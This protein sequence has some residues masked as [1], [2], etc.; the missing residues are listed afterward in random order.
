VFVRDLIINVRFSFRGIFND[1][2]ILSERF[3]VARGAYTF[4]NRI[5]IHLSKIFEGKSIP[6]FFMD[7]PFTADGLDI[8]FVR[9]GGM[10]IGIRAFRKAESTFFTYTHVIFA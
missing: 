6:G 4:L 5:Y 7:H 10:S 3:L 8:F 9:S 1:L 2:C